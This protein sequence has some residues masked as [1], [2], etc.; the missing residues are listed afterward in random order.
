MSEEPSLE[1]R[2]V[3]TVECM[4]IDHEDNKMKPMKD[5]LYQFHAQINF[6]KLHIIHKLYAH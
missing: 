3:T 1:W 4:F 2:L 6:V 5:K